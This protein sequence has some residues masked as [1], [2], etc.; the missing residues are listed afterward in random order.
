MAS[1]GWALDA[2]KSGSKV[3]RIG[4]NGKGMWLYFV[5][6]VSGYKL[7]PNMP[8]Y[9]SR[10]TIDFNSRIDMYTADGKI[11]PG[12]LASQTDMLADDWGVA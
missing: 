2:M 4:W 9:Y 6:G 10:D 5:P 1:F 3:S 8:W 11:Q 7:T 12:W